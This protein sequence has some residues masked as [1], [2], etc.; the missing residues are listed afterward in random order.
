[1]PK[2]IFKQKTCTVVH[3]TS[4]G[5]NYSHTFR[6]VFGLGIAKTKMLDLKI[7]NPQITDV[8]HR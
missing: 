8:I 4:G 2:E 5:V 3:Y 1:M 7:G 6:G